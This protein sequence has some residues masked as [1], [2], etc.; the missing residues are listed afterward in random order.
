[1][2]KVRL[3]TF[4]GEVRVIELPSR[5]AVAQFISAYP[6]KLPTGISIKIAVDGLGISGVLRGRA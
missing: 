4:N 6:E 3:E 2:F 1:M 5:G